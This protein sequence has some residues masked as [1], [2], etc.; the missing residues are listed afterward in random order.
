MR[1]LQIKRDPC[2]LAFVNHF[3]GEDTQMKKNY[4]FAG[5]LAL[6]SA[7]YVLSG[8]SHNSVP[9][10]SNTTGSHDASAKDKVSVVCTSFPQYDWVCRLTEGLD[11]KFE[12]IFEYLEIR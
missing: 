3:L 1:G 7:A 10:V 4:I 12:I 6:T 8:C 11:D 5:L 2:K 9:E